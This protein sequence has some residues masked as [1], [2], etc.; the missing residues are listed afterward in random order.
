MSFDF[1]SIDFQAI[2]QAFNNFASQNPIV[3][4][5]EIFLGGGW[6]FFAIMIAYGIYQVWL[7]ARQG[8]FAGK[9]KWV[10]LAIDIPKNNEQTPKAVESIFVALAGA[11]KNPNLVDRYWEGW[12]QESFSFEVISLE[13]YIQFV[14][15]VPVH[16]R[17]LME[18]AVY[19]QYPDAEIT[20]IDD[21]AAP[22]KDLRFP[23][24]KYN[25]WGTELVLVK[26]FPFPIRTYP[27]FEHSMTQ[28]L[29]DPMAGL[30]EI[31]SRFGPGEQ[32]WL[33]LV[34]TPQPPGW[35]EKAKKVM[36]EFIGKPYTPPATLTDRLAKPVEWMGTGA[37]ELLNSAV[38]YQTEEKKKEDDQ[39][40][41]F[42]L[43]PGQRNVMEKVE[44]KLS[45]HA[46][47]VKFRMIYLAEKKV[48]SKGRGVAAV[49][50]AIQ[51]FNTA[52]ANG[53]KPGK[54][55]KT[56]VD[57]FRVGPRTAYRQNFLLSQYIRR[58]NYYGEEVSN[59][60]LNTEELASIWHFPVMTV[61]ATLVEKIESKKAAPP[62]RLPYQIRELAA[63]KA[64]AGSA[65]AETEMS[66]PLRPIAPQT[67]SLND[68]ESID[69]IPESEKEA[70][71]PS[72]PAVRVRPAAT[73]AAAGRKSSPPPNLPVV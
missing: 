55:T 10:V 43:T 8:Q 68:L 41:M 28:S 63:K 26:D 22:Y 17:D 49:I 36:A 25:M 20:E 18:A 54:R 39:W 15:R 38:G 5:V 66:A 65:T 34:V 62:S 59:M 71:P 9:W 27:E 56:A 52:D 23:N 32:L 2:L 29:I 46:F 42:K 31:L 72:K 3:I 11:Q 45:R 4:S 44:N 6:V 58:G 12:L 53:F 1:S 37:V 40:K 50:G 73:G 47:R 48:F 13:G 70:P 16:F 19:A 61:K 21:Y 24:D 7:D 60:F 35:G 51:Q 33:Q 67:P 69:E 64:D 57:Y 30:L 14:V